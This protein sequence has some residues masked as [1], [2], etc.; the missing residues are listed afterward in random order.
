MSWSTCTRPSAIPPR[1]RDVVDSSIVSTVSN[2]MR[3]SCMQVTMEMVSKLEKMS[4][5]SRHESAV[6]GLMT[7]AYGV[8]IKIM[9]VGLY[10]YEQNILPSIGT[11]LAYSP[12]TCTG[13]TP[14]V[15][16][17]SQA[18]A[19]IASRIKMD[20]AIKKTKGEV[21]P[22]NT[23]SVLVSKFAMLLRCS[24]VCTAIGVAFTNC[25][26][27]PVDNMAKRMRCSSLFSEWLGEMIK[28]HH[29]FG[30]R[31]TVIGMGAFAADSVRN[32]F[33][34]YKGLSSDVNY[35]GVTNPAAISYMNVTKYTTVSPIPDQTTTV[36]MHISD[37]AGVQVS[38]D[39]PVSYE[40][41]VYPRSV[42]NEHMGKS[43]IGPLARALV[44]HT[45]DDLTSY[46]ITMARNLFNN[47]G[48]T[49]SSRG[50]AVSGIPEDAGSGSVQGDNANTQTLQQPSGGLFLKQGEVQQH[51]A[52]Q[53]Q[54]QQ[55]SQYDNG[56]GF[57][58]GRNT[59]IAQMQDPT[60][61][62]KSQQVIVVENL[63]AKVNEILESYR[64]G[65]AIMITLSKKMDTLLAAG[66][67][68]LGGEEVESI[69]E[70]YKQRFEKYLKNMEQGA[71]IIGGM[72]AVLE[73]DTGVFE[74]EIQ[75]AAPIMRRY[76]GSTMRDSVYQQVLDDRN[77]GV[78]GMRNPPTNT[79][80]FT[81]PAVVANMVSTT[82]APSTEFGVP[83]QHG[84]TSGE[85]ME[86][87]AMRRTRAETLIFA[88]LEGRED[89]QL[90]ES[91]MKEMSIAG[92]EKV[93]MME[94]ATSIIAVYMRETA[95]DGP[96][97]DSVA[98]LFSMM[99]PYTSETLT[100]VATMLTQMMESPDD[101]VQF[102]DVDLVNG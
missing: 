6:R 40:W 25:V 101:V 62:T 89:D 63:L 12:M 58:V 82:T 14:S 81:N 96:S 18:M 54:G 75:P 29:S 1:K 37:I 22:E 100:E 67:G 92:N 33:S 69:T 27:V 42:L 79:G 98:Q 10:P 60:G 68:G 45:V 97:W 9:C 49:G 28:I 56:S 38:L 8:P 51:D 32:T 20:A 30:F 87:N 35:L 76:D 48:S 88:V 90:V 102:F 95:S 43:K 83:N 47:I 5:G 50:I 46:F 34:S 84:N 85:A 24:Y 66:P 57:M 74:N 26:P 36:E 59:M 71:M 55:R 44:D 65:E 17:L 11:A 7:I 39:A 61:K 23:E 3:H 70:A 93:D 16:I 2:S 94:I 77:S 91:M 21:L 4:F 52:V 64:G 99:A 31:M 80:I 19:A 78:A 15:Q 13:C 53:A 86:A 72:P 41:N 73:G